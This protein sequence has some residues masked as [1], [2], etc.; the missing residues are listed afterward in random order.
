MSTDRTPA[1]LHGDEGELS[2]V[3]A[4][5][6]AALDRGEQPDRDD[7]LDRFPHLAERLR[8]FFVSEDGFGRLAAPLRHGTTADDVPA[9][10]DL[11]EEIGRGGM[12][13]V[14]R[15]RD[16]ILDRELA[17]KVLLD[18]FRDDPDFVRRF[19]EEARITGQLQHPFIVPVHEL[20]TLPDGRPYFAMKLVQGRTLAD[21]L[22]ERPNPTHDLPR[23]LKV[24]EQVC[25]T[26]AYAHSRGVI[27]RDLKPANVMVGAFGEVQVMDWGLAKL[28]NE[29]ARP[30]AGD[31]SVPGAAP[32][33]QTQNGSV[34]GTFA[35]MPPEQASGDVGRID[36]RSDVFGLGA[37][38]C[39]IL[40]GHPPYTGIR[41]EVREKA[42]GGLTREAH[43]RLQDCGA[44]GELI[45][46]AWRCLAVDVA[47]R[48]ADGGAVADAMASYFAAVQQRMRAAEIARAKAET[49]AVGERKRVALAEAKAVAE[50]K[51]A[52]AERRRRRATLLTA[53]SLLLLVGGAS[54]FGLWYQQRQGERA[55]ETATRR[56]AT[57]RDVSGA[58][59]E[60]GLLRQE[61]LK[62]ADDPRRWELTLKMAHSALQRAEDALR[63][64]EPADALANQVESARTAL[65]Q[66]ERVC[67]LF[68]TL[69]RLRLES[70]VFSGDDVRL[71]DSV[72]QIGAAFKEYGLD[73]GAL[74][75]DEAAAILRRHP[76][77]DRLVDEIEA[78]S[79]AQAHWTERWRPQQVQKGFRGVLVRS[80]DWS[81]SERLT[82]VLDAV[83]PDPQSFHRRW[84]AARAMNDVGALTALAHSPQAGTLSTLGLCTLAGDLI[85]FKSFDEALDFLKERRE[86]EPNNFWLNMY[87]GLVTLAAD[88]NSA[89]E[90]IR[91]FHEALAA[92]GH[93]AGIY[94]L[95]SQARRLK[96]DAEGALKAARKA[97]ELDPAGAPAHHALGSLQMEQGDLDGAYQSFRKA[98]ELDAVNFY[99]LDALG[100]VCIERKEYDEAIRHL[101]L[102][103]QRYPKFA[104][105]YVNLGNAYV[106]KGSVDGALASYRTAVKLFP[107]YGLAHLNMGQVLQA[108]RDFDGAER[109]YRAAIQGDPDF[110]D[111]YKALAQLLAERGDGASALRVYWIPVDRDPTSVKA[112]VMSSQMLL[113]ARDDSGAFRCAHAA[114][115]LDPSSAGAHLALIGALLRNGK[116]D[117][118]I[119]RGEDAL[120]PCPES[121]ELH[122][123]LGTAFYWKCEFDRA[124]RSHR[125]ALR[126]K[127]GNGVTYE[128]IGLAL[129]AAGDFERA[130]DAF[131]QA[132]RYNWKGGSGDNLLAET[133]LATRKLAEAETAARKAVERNPA[134][135][136][137]YFTLARIRAEGGDYAGAKEAMRR[138][139]AALPPLDPRRVQ[140]R[141]NIGSLEVFEEI[142]RRLPDVLAGK[143]KKPATPLEQLMFGIVCAK[144]HPRLHG[145]AAALL[146][147]DAY[148]AQPSFADNMEAGNRTLAATC[149]VLAATG[150]SEDAAGLEA[151]EKAALLRRARGWFRADLDAMNK[152]YA[153]RD[154]ITRATVRFRIWAWQKSPDLSG[155]REPA[156][157]V[158]FP[159]EEREAWITLWDEL[160][161]L[162]KRP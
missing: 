112:L 38:L 1:Y 35:F 145:V 159:T 76:H 37:I 6:L 83:E 92:R 68:L 75:V 89:D 91:Y 118:A 63:R 119:R 14:L 15:G 148:A 125:Q 116:V 58:L 87:L 154:P 113:A 44:D 25:Q 9:T 47:A 53:A 143:D 86:R 103:I 97:V 110:V 157:M 78:W 151:E 54:A 17:I 115:E 21:L 161:A 77:R 85:T 67:T 33:D 138:A 122:D 127:P 144:H 64:G 124:V 31:S 137:G 162:A 93:N 55:A 46:L 152:A 39:E 29:T 60:V 95:L 84:H 132:A 8:A 56:A 90:A 13:L 62:Q 50:E 139:E 153:R 16:R 43:D 45:D 99:P 106:R 32:A 111:A 135:L 69:E 156:E 131:R 5:Y 108:K 41:D 105:T 101:R 52:R 158:A 70:A 20:G 81:R 107:E 26:L 79:Q 51:R 34:L 66:D 74:G 88:L 100:Q 22:A 129:R 42:R 30:P 120:A 19:I 133:L 114:L 57:E 126:L 98:A 4:E 65:R 136:A 149:A 96:G 130:I 150:A 18:A 94:I 27:H 147:T 160:E 142:Q 23:Y 48:P 140:F 49:E 104:A 11:I 80:P 73:F 117:E 155:V 36:R 7:L 121:P 82:R 109:C 2:V 40:T 141:Q 128:N 134:D 102:A 123:R 12:G 3:L 10:F 72:A 59:G 24:F 61:G 146:L 28:L 71:P